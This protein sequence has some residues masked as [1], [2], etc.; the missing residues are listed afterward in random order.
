MYSSSL[1]IPELD[2]LIPHFWEF[3]QSCAYEPFLKVH[4]TSDKTTK[5]IQRLVN[6]QWDKKSE[7]TVVM[8]TASFGHGQQV[9]DVCIKNGDWK[10]DGEMQAGLGDDMLVPLGLL[11]SYR[12]KLYNENLRT[13]CFY[14]GGPASHQRILT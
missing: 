1:T 9:T 6:K 2:L 3:T 13:F 12:L 14:G 5:E 8:R 10:Q 11:A 7:S 4:R